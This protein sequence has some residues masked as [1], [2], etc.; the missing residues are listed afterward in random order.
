MTTGHKHRVLTLPRWVIWTLQ[1]PIWRTRNLDWVDRSRFPFGS[2]PGKHFVDF[3]AEVWYLSIL[4]VLHGWFGLCVRT[5]SA[6]AYQRGPRHVL[7][8]QIAW[9]AWC[10][11][12]EHVVFR[13][14]R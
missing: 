2:H 13:W 11:N 8:N 1:R 4:A 14:H 7:M 12:C 9:R 6:A 3:D 5:R 10:A